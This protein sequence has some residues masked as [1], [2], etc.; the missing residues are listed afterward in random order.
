MVG[1]KVSNFKI[2]ALPLIVPLIMGILLLLNA[3]GN[4]RL[5]SA[6]GSDFI[7]LVAAGFCFGMVFGIGIAGF[8]SSRG[9]KDVSSHTPG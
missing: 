7:K 6:H 8:A 5:Q 2:L 4:P 9:A 1:G 3:V